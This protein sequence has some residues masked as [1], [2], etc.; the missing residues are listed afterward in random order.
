MA[1]DGFGSDLWKNLQAVRLDKDGVMHA[2]VNV[3]G[4]DGIVVG[5]DAIAKNEAATTADSTDV[6]V[7]RPWWKRI[8]RAQS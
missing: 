1:N 4:K 2:P 6:P 3:D 7:R 5:V 8:G